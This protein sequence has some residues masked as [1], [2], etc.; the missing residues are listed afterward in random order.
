MA[1]PTGKLGALLA[2][3]TAA[4]VE[5]EVIGA[6]GPGSGPFNTK[7][8][9]IDYLRNNPKDDP[10]GPAQQTGSQ[11]TPTVPGPSEL[12]LLKTLADSLTDLHDHL[13][14]RI[15]AVKDGLNKVDENSLKRDNQLQ[16]QLATLIQQ[17]S[18]ERRVQYA[19][20]S[21]QALRISNLEATVA[22]LAESHRKQVGLLHRRVTKRKA[23]IAT[24]SNKRQ[25]KRVSDHSA[26]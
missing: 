13:C 5:V 17:D 18:D 3:L 4:G 9:L 15:K 14:P 24:K 6:G 26:D 12:A 22:S 20:V 19:R 10:T 21:D 23:E 1:L 8:E 11:E 16:Q 25:S 7:E 2:A